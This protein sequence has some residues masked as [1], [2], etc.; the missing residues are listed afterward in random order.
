MTKNKHAIAALT[1]CLWGAVIVGR[2][3]IEKQH[4]T[5]SAV[6]KKVIGVGWDPRN[7]ATLDRVVKDREAQAFKE[8][9]Y[10]GKQAFVWPGLR[11]MQVSYTW[12]QLLQGLH[13][14][15]S[16]EGDYSWMFSKLNFIARETPR[17]DIRFLT[18]L[19]SFFL[20]IGKDAI[21]ANLLLREMQLRTPA[22]WQVWFWSGFHAI[23]NLNDKQLASYFMRQSSL[24]PYSPD[25]LVSLSLRLA[26]GNNFFTGDVKRKL[27]EEQLPPELVE[28]LL[29]TRKL[30]IE[31][32]D[33]E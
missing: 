1:L 32:E 18:G 25:Y 22:N 6:D 3:Q 27:L 9:S 23:E 20:V 15:S 12:L 28:K 14:L 17:E 8:Q 26:N 11:A 2:L 5:R 10:S 30:E 16:S 13:N 24:R 31:G 29:K 7:I 19:A 21:G 33:V 4:F